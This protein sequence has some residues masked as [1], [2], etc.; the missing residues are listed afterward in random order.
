MLLDAQSNLTDNDPRHDEVKSSGDADGDAEGQTVTIC[1][2]LSIVAVIIGVCAIMCYREVSRRKKEA[3]IIE[4][5]AR[6]E[7]IKRSIK[8]KLKQLE[9]SE[10]SNSYK[11]H[12]EVKVPLVQFNDVVQINRAV[13]PM[14]SME[15][16]DK[17]HKIA[18]PPSRKRIK[19]PQR[20]LHM[21]QS[22]YDNIIRLQHQRNRV[23]MKIPQREIVHCTQLHSSYNFCPTRDSDVEGIHSKQN[24]G[25]SRR[26]LHDDVSQ[27]PLGMPL[28]PPAPN[29]SWYSYIRNLLTRQEVPSTPKERYTDIA[30]VERDTKH[31]TL[32]IV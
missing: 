29:P 1:I 17:I 30:M 28:E 26:L 23:V 15:D 18:Q 6:R 2:S 8:E 11:E 22:Y 5:H 16:I 25:A 32:K 3:L 21:Y 4:E 20:P 13:T 24:N 19:R 7:S 31:A 10:D 9:I 27:H 12:M 14:N